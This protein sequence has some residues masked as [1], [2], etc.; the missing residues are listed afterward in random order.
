MP[1]GESE[2]KAKP[3]RYRCVKCDAVSKKKQ[4]LCQPKKI[5]ATKRRD[6]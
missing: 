1:C 5:K 6:K 3:G 4:H 2:H